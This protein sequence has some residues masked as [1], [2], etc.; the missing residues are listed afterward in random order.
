MIRGYDVG[1]EV[2]W[3]AHNTLTTGTICAIYR[4]DTEIEIDGERVPVSVSASSPTYLIEQHDGRK[5]IMA[6]GDVVLKSSNLH[7]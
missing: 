4:Q 3:N 2:K 6:H 7:T 5:C 1:T